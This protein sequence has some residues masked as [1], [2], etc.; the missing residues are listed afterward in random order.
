VNAGPNGGLDSPRTRRRFLRDAGVVTG[1]AALGLAGAEEALAPSRSPQRGRRQTVAV[2][3]GGVAGLTAAHELVERG[4]D[5]TVYER[6]A[7]G[8]KARSMD[9]PR[10]ARGGRRPLPGEHGFRIVLGFYQNLPDTLKRIPFG[11]NPGGVFDNMVPASHWRLA[12][13]GGSDL[14]VPFR[15][16]GGPRDYTLEE[17]AQLPIALLQA[18]FA[19]DAA[20]HFADRLT[21][22]FS[23]CEGRRVGQ[24]ENT[25]WTDF[26]GSDRYSGF[27]R[28]YVA[29]LPRLIQASHGERTSANWM[30]G[31][32]E[33]LIY[34]LIGRGSTGPFDRPLNAPTN[35]AWI[36][37]WLALLRKLGVR[38]R[39][40]QTVTA[41]DLRR[42]R[43]GGARVRGPRGT[44][45]V[46]ADWYVC[47]L[48]VERARALWSGAIRAADPR[49]AGMDKLQTGRM[50]GIQFYLRRPTPIVH[51]HVAYVDAPWAVTSVSQAQFW[52]RDFAASYGDGRAQDCLSTIVSDWS[53]P[54]RI[55]GKPARELTPHQVASEVWEQMKRHLNDSGS[56]EL[57]DDLLVS[58]HL[59]P[60]LTYT[61]RGFRNADPLTSPTAGSWSK[62]P[63]VT[64]AIPNLLLA[65]DYGSGH[66]FVGTMESAN[67]AGRLAAN[68]VLERA[69]SREPRAQVIGRYRPPEWE[70]HK[71][72]DEQRWANGQPN[73][74][75]TG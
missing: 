30:A 65:G 41:F 31:A 24:W 22:F 39:L 18:D 69:G 7:W 49:L 15:P 68:A 70:S 61:S 11:T 47:A 67:K 5:V 28:D 1:T 32:L 8:G 53:Q 14:I 66:W 16:P 48:P 38:L 3:G 74:Y 34:N 17:I 19:P 35:E 59:D 12:R 51:G 55:Y 71:R 60:G 64:T 9:V 36:E 13:E 26:I 25:P 27:Y 21:V 45:T 72:V 73:I 50:N 75:D 10:S 43:I 2:F 40:G 42:G 52:D 4:F 54:G 57:T 58:W 62:R 6:R 20:A 29:E 46:R 63:A 56:A 23:S 37:P 44:R 33:A